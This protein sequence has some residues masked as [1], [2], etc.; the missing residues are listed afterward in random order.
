[1]EESSQDNP[2]SSTLEA[3]NKA[4]LTMIDVWLLQKSYTG[5]ELTDTLKVQIS[6]FEGWIGDG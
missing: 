6:H 1:M 3:N 4:K 5:S 2:S